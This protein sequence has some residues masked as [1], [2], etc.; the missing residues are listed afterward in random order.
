ML[1]RMDQRDRDPVI[2]RIAK[3]YRERPPRKIT[4]DELNELSARVLR[5]KMRGSSDV[6]RLE[7]RLEDYTQ[8]FN[9]QRKSDRSTGTGTGERSRKTEDDMTIEEM[10]REE[11]TTGGTQSSIVKN[12][13]KDKKYSNDLEY[14]EENL[15][16][17]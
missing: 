7:R 17:Y 8:R 10:L 16:M 1:T 14:Q 4:Q 13:M 15:L 2:E 12:I 3:D 11:R 5:N 9:E 6:E